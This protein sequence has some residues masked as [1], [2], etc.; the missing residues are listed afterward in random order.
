MWALLGIGC[1]LIAVGDAV[2]AVQEARNAYVEGDYDFVWT[3]GALV[4]AYAAWSSVPGPI[5]HPD[6]VGWRAIALPV[7]AQVLAGGI[8]V[9]GLFAQQRARRHAGRPRRRDRADHPVAS[10]PRR[11]RVDPSGRSRRRPLK[12]PRATPITGPWAPSPP[13]I[14]ASPSGTR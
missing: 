6:P 1:V 12:R 11:L 9:Y 5:V 3:L 7:A 10:A 14:R 13:S 8:Q 4:V 2:F